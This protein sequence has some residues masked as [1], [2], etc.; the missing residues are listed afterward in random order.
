MSSHVFVVCNLLPNP[1]T[2]G[3]G[4][5]YVGVELGWE[6]DSKEVKKATVE[7]RAFEYVLEFTTKPRR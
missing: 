2:S 4:Q 3:R 6:A 7:E 5:I 1:S